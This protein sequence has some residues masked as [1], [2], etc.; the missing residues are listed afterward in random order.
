MPRLDC[1]TVSAEILTPLP[2]PKNTTIKTLYSP[3]ETEQSVAQQLQEQVNASTLGLM[4]GALK[5][6]FKGST[7]DP[8]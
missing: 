2:P 3:G 7:G 5:V 1:P 4:S 6:S 8:V